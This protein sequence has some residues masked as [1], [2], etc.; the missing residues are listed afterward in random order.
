MLKIA[1]Q[2]KIKYYSLIFCLLIIAC[3]SIFPTHIL[4]SAGT[5]ASLTNPIAESNPVKIVAYVIRAMLGVLGAITL[6][7]FIY[8]GFMLVF[9][10]GNEE[11]LKK[12][13]GTLVWAIIGMAIVL[14]S[15]SILSYL[16]KI[17]ATSTGS[18][19]T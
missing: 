13:R 15:Y 6:L 7:M 17:L 3:F 10:G 5:S 2:K 12:G 16:F 9:S 11:Q 19:S 18:S 1:H 14:S 4:L 8:G